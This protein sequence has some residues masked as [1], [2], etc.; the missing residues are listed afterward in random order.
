MSTVHEGPGGL[1]LELEH[2]DIDKFIAS[3]AAGE[4]TLTALLV[5]CGVSIATAGIIGACIVAH[6]AWETGAILA[7]DQGDGVVLS[8]PAALWLLGGGGIVI[9]STRHKREIPD[10]WV[11]DRDGHFKTQGGDVVQ[12]HIDGGGDPEQVAF[13]LR[14]QCPS[15]WAKA[16]I[17]RD[18]EG[19]EWWVRADQNAQGEN[20]LWA[21]QV[22]NGQQIS[23]WKP[24]FLGQWQPV[25]DIGNLDLLVGGDVVTFSWTND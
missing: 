5:A 2:D 15:G 6:A 14:A 3:I 10:T 21:G 18:G 19:N 20:G 7:S 4:G 24:A 12:F 17:L 23:F 25:F 11:T 8:A 22:K 16:L 13:R 9:P 1:Q